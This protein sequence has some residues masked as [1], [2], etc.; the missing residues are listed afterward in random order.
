MKYD[1]R[2]L[3]SLKESTDLF[4]KMLNCIPDKNIEENLEMYV[5]NVVND[6]DELGMEIDCMLEE[7]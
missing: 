6:L 7:E 4:G 2:I 5:A 1:K 3:K